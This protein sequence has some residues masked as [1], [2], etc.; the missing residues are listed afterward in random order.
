MQ[1]VTRSHKLH[2]TEHSILLCRDLQVLVAQHSDAH[3]AWILKEILGIALQ[4]MLPA[5]DVHVYG[6]WVFTGVKA[7][8]ECV[9]ILRL[10]ETEME[11]SA[12]Y[13]LALAK[14]AKQGQGK[15][16]SKDVRPEGQA[17]S[18]HTH[19]TVRA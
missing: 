17:L 19:T 4:F 5:L 7:A 3:P 16:N 1:S 10:V 14:Q 12:A 18:K 15:G 2:N 11:S 8:K 6:E 13:K 9:S